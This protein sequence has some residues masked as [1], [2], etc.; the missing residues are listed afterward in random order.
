MR[1]SVDLPQPDGPTT[2]T[3][4]PLSTVN[5]T[6]LK[7]SVPSGKIIPIPSNVNDVVTTLVPLI[8]TDTPSGTTVTVTG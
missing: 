5:D 8:L 6:L 7:A 3:N 4:S 1:K 2:V